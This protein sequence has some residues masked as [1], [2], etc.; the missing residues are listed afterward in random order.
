MMMMK[1]DTSYW[2]WFD[3]HQHSSRRSPWL[4]STLGDLDQKTRTM[5]KLIEEDADS[6]AQRA[7]MYYK[8]RPEL[9]SMVEDFYK[10]HRSLAE[11]Y[12][13]LKSESANR[14]VTTLGHPFSSKSRQPKLMA[15]M[16]QFDKI[17]DG[18][19]M[20]RMDQFD[21]I[22]DSRS[23][24]GMDQFDKIG[25]SRSMPGMDQFDKI[26]D[27]RS[28]PEMDK[29]DKISNDHS[30]A[31]MDQ[32]DKV[33]DSCSETGSYDTEESAESEVDDPEHEVE[34]LLENEMGEVEEPGDEI[35][36]KENEVGVFSNDQVIK[37]QEEIERLK[38]ENKIQQDQLL[39]KDEEKREVIRQLSFAVEVL[40]VE[41]MNLR[42]SAARDPPKKKSIFEFEKLK[43][44][45]SGKYFSR[46]R[47]AAL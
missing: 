44:V 10:T 23:M 43:D 13:L 16:D 27:S 4:Q 46:G 9:I 22:G 37:L 26:S 38:A 34:T 8:K 41:N 3:S 29:F 25:D 42:K 35:E 30:T 19:S 17:G 45:F 15:G 21:K 20:A 31:G 6:F 33:Y 5:L 11:R 2:W 47:V 14:L 28:M 32:F 7:E 1:R 40:M 18:R 24:A 36:T 39:Q 12:D